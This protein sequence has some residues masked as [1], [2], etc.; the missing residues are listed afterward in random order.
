[1][2]GPVDPAATDDGRAAGVAALYVHLPFCRGGRCP[3]CDFYSTVLDVDRPDPTGDCLTPRPDRTGDYLRAVRGEAAWWAERT[4]NTESPT[5]L[6]LGGGTPTALP[7]SDL[8]ELVVYIRQLF[9]LAQDA[10][11]SCEANPGTV[12]E[13]CLHRLRR[14]GVNRLSLGVQS[15]DPDVLRR[16]GRRHTPEEA[17]RAVTLAR[18]AGFEA[19]GID[20]MFGLPGQTLNSWC[21]TLARAIELRPGHVA[22]YALKVAADTPFGAELAAGRLGLP[23]EDEAAEMYEQAVS[24]LTAAGYEHYEV[25]NFALPR[26]RCRHNLAYWH[27]DRYLGLGAAAHSH[28]PGRRLANPADLGAYV[29]GVEAGSLPVGVVET[30][31]LRTEM[32]DTVIMGLR[33]TDGIEEARFQRRFGRTM[34]KAFPEAVARLTRLGLLETVATG[35]GAAGV[36]GQGL[37]RRLT[38]RGLRLANRALAEF[39]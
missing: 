3:Y 17:C 36:P 29:T 20:L 38:P 27:N 31:S 21:D 35:N 28:L 33:L 19:L 15:L 9:A 6:Y 34:E 11:V 23:D 5:T 22:A 7:V 16:A 12:D 18:R 8:E 32:I 10:E 24:Q 4:D 25:S 2:S 26:R 39:V 13:G 1:M 14:A 37:R 30:L